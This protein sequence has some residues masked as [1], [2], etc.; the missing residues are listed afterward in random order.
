MPKLSFWFSSWSVHVSCPALSTQWEEHVLLSLEACSS[1]RFKLSY[2]HKQWLVLGGWWCH[3]IPDFR[4]VPGQAV[5]ALA[6]PKSS[7]SHRPDPVYS[8]WDGQSDLYLWSL[9]S[10][11]L[12]APIL[13]LK[14]RSR[15][16]PLVPPLAFWHWSA[17]GQDTSSLIYCLK[18]LCQTEHLN[19]ARPR[20]W[21]CYMEIM[22][23]KSSFQISK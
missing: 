9:G 10:K 8:P 14:C 4:A 11:T 2:M 18:L 15:H 20:Q 6:H 3:R 19:F 22:D 23:T 12:A 7:V 16:Q 17:S 5:L 1:S 13:I 21:C